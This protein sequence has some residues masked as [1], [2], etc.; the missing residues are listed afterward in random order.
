MRSWQR[1]LTETGSRRATEA[2]LPSAEPQTFSTVASALQSLPA[3]SPQSLHDQID[4][5]GPWIGKQDFRVK[6]EFRERKQ[7]DRI[8]T[9]R[10]AA[11]GLR[12]G[13]PLT[14]I[15]GH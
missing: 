5:R 2:Y 13:R 11:S 14:A 7:R 1:L 8:E 15:K 12:H 9:P 3:P 4:C 10:L 6:T